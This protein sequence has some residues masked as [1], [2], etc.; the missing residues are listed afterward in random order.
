MR[1]SFKKWNWA[2]VTGGVILLFSLL[3]IVIEYFYNPMSVG[4][5]NPLFAPLILIG[6]MQIFLNY[7][8]GFYIL[9]NKNV[10]EWFRSN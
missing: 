9:F 6:F 7:L 5:I 2:R 10:K 1:A 8:I 3:N 4:S